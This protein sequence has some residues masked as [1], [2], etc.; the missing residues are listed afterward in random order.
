MTVPGR[1]ARTRAASLALC[2]GL[3]VGA[4]GGA[5]S[6][7]PD[8]VATPMSASCGP[9]EHPPEQPSGHLVGDAEPPTAYTSVPP[10]SGWHTTA[11]PEP[12]VVHDG[13]RDP[14]LVAALEA[15]HVVLA[16][17][18]DVAADAAASDRID[19]A[20][21]QFADRLVVTVFAEPMPSPVALLTWGGL[22]RCDDVTLGDVTTFVL[23][24][25]RTAQEH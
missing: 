23:T 14:D 8:P 24:E 18:P 22:V 11:V 9:V 20:R 15:G 2:V 3:V 16:V 21:A 12:G 1:R 17:A 25:R 19:E 10:T 13:L 4:C 7:A 6:S 5:R